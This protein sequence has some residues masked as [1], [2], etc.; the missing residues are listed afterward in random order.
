MASNKNSRR[1]RW[2]LLIALALHVLALWRYAPDLRARV[3]QALA[4]EPETVE[5]VLEIGEPPP[6]PEPPRERWSLQT[7]LRGGSPEALPPPLPENFFPRPSSAG[8][9]RLELS[10][11]LAQPPRAPD[12][13]PAA[14][15]TAPVVPAVVRLPDIV[16]VSPQPRTPRPSTRAP[17]RPAP[18][19]T[20]V[21][22]APEPRQ[23]E[24]L[25]PIRLPPEDDPALDLAI[26]R[27]AEDAERSA[28]RPPDAAPPVDLRKLLLQGATAQTPLRAPDGTR[29]APPP[30]EAGITTYPLDAA[31]AP[32]QTRAAP[33]EGLA[34]QAPNRAQYFARVTA[35]LKATNQRRLAESVRVG[36]RATVRMKFTVDRSGRLLDVRSAEVADAEV[37]ARAAEVVRAAAPFPGIPEAMG[38]TRLEL[39]FPIEVYR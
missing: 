38:Q 17:L 22:V 20:A 14:A 9:A 3:E 33:D 31:I 16:A 39:S 12:P 5:Q 4:D 24:P 30:P 11:R 28:R 36:S 18:P 15:A 26:T 10:A 27:A 6:P 25:P 35:Q 37:I 19:V 7:S 32:D 23:A 2:A 34:D 1:L 8:T 21:E 13:V 29:P